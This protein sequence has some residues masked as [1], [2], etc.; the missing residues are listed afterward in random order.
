MYVVSRTKHGS[1]GQPAG[2][3]G[4]SSTHDTKREAVG[5][6]RD[7]AKRRGPRSLYVQKI[8][9]R[10][11]EQRTRGGKDPLLPKG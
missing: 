10:I 3:T 11:Q 1:S 5:T 8:D 4:A 2:G 6:G 9:G 7:L